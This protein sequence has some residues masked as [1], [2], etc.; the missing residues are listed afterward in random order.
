M[1]MVNPKGDKRFNPGNEI[2]KNLDGSWKM[3][4]TQ[5]RMG[6]FPSTGYSP[7]TITTTKE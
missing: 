1:D 6:V 7:G 3:T 2:T 4:S 5:V